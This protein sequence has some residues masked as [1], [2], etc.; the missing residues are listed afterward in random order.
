MTAAKRTHPESAL[1]TQIKKFVRDCVS[2]PHIFAA[3]DRS[4]DHSGVQHMWEAMR[5]LKKHWPDTE[6]L[7]PAGITFRCELK[8]AGKQIEADGGQAKLGAEIAALGHPWAWA[9][10]VQSYLAA[11][12]AAGVPF[13][14][15]ADL[16]ALDLDLVLE[17]R[18]VKAPG[19]KSYV[20]QKP[21]AKKPSA[22]AIARTHAARGRVMF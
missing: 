1:Q 3:H 8:A 10:S 17:G 19:P 11:A 15:S 13:H 9:N 16:R 21:R 20:A 14:P 6:L 4:K 7:L 22:S 2:C 18:H 5:G 12:R